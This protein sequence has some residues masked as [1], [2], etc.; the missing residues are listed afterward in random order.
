[1]KIKWIGKY[2][3]NNLP[4]TKVSEDAH[5]LPPASTKSAILI[6]PIIVVFITLVLIKSQLFTGLTVTRLY[7]T[8][9]LIIGFLL[10][11]VHE[12]LHA[13]CFPP[14]SSVYMFFTNQGLGTTCLSP[15]TRNRFILINLVP[16]II[17]GIIPLIAFMGFPKEYVAANSILFAVAFLHIGGSYADYINVFHT[18]KVPKD[19]TIQISGEK[20]FWCM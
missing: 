19:A 2:T 1:M 6:V 5:E 7:L 18:I 14:N 9:G 4:F 15:V 8:I 13:I 10:F 20:I 12:L 3:G 16:S 11:P 17:L